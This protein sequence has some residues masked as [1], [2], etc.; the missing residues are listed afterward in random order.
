MGLLTH[1]F[2]FIYIKKPTFLFHDFLL[3]SF[4][5]LVLFAFSTDFYK[6]PGNSDYCISS[7][8]F[9]LSRLLHLM[10]AN[11]TEEMNVFI[12]AARLM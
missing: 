6:N 5:L 2:F 1:F 10:E 8:K 3:V 4:I 7:Q 9:P 11:F 12:T